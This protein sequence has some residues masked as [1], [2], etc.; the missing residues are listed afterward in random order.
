MQ[1]YADENIAAQRRQAG[2]NRSHLKAYRPYLFIIL[3][4]ALIGTCFAGA[5]QRGGISHLNGFIAPI[6]GP[7]SRILPPNADQFKYWELNNFLFAVSVT[8]I[9]LFSIAAS[10]LPKHRI[11]RRLTTAAACLA[12]VFWCLCGL[13]KVI[14]ELT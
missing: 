13:F 4:S 5:A 8:L 11:L 3:L 10:R 12:V 2:E 7:W 9:T 6:L 14:L 1:L